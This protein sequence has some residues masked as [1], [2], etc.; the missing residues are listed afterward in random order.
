MTL[1]QQAKQAFLQGSLLLAVGVLIGAFGAHGLKSMVEAEKLTTFET[2][3]RYHFYHA[4]GIMIV[5]LIQQLCPELNLKSVTKVFLLGILFFS[6]NCYIYVVSGLKIFALL[7]PV[8]GFL[9][10][11]G[12]IMMFWKISSL[13]KK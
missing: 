8:G 6:F 2:G 12:W 5:G 1:H 9:F 13:G 11:I 3:V 7:V 10:I 4:L